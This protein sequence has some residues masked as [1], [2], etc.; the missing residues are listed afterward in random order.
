MAPSPVLV[1]ACLSSLCT[2]SQTPPSPAQTT[3]KHREVCSSYQ[4][5][6]DW[7]L[8]EAEPRLYQSTFPKAPEPI[9]L[10][11]S[12]KQHKKT[13]QLVPQI[14]HSVGGL[15]RHQSPLKWILLYMVSCHTKACCCSHG[16]SSQ[17]VRLRINP[18]HWH[19]NNN[20]VST[21]IK[22]HTQSAPLEHWA[23]V[24]GRLHHCVP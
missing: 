18:T 3:N 1:G 6:L 15:N 10:V 17:P 12:F 11:A 23:Q 22:E 7:T 20:Q 9:H 13:A 8:A 2:P 5:A 21:T 24:T 4:V 19:A 16:Q 14:S